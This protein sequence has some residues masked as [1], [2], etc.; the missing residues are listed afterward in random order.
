MSVTI[1]YDEDQFPLPFDASSSLRDVLEEFQEYLAAV[2]ID[3][4][5]LPALG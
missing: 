3:A 2:V 4:A 1:G 5:G